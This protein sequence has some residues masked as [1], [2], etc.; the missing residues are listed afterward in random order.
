MRG[1]LTGLRVAV[2]GT[3]AAAWHAARLLGR[4]GA[5]VAAQADNH[6]AAADW[7]ASGVMA[8]TGRRDGPPV[9]PPGQTASAVRGALRAIE[10]LCA[11]AGREVDLPG[12]GVL[13]ERAALAGLRRDAP[14]SPGGAF[15]VLR[16]ADAWVGLNLPRQSDVDLL[17]AWLEEADPV[18]DEAVARRRAG[19]LAERARLLGLPF[20][21]LPSEPDEQS[22]ARG[23][24]PFVLTGEPGARSWTLPPTVV[25]DLSSLW[26]GPLCAH[27]LGLTGARVIKV[28][29][30]TRPD[31]ARRGPR[32][33]YDLLHAGHESVVLDFAAAQ[34]R[35]ALAGLLDA[36]DVVI[37]GSRPRALRQ[38]GIDADE[39]L[40]R[41]RDK[42]WIGITAYGRTGPWANVPGFGDD[43][44]L[45]AGLLAFDPGTGGPVPCGDAI[46]DPVTG[47]NAALMAVACR[48]SGG[49][50]L[51]D[52]ALREQ[53]AAT[54]VDT[55]EP[56]LPG[57]VARPRRR[58]PA[59]VAAELGRDTG[60]V[61]AE[62]GLPC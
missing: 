17:P 44:A 14:R 7:A 49:A 37:E 48:M 47:V 24:V 36:A 33:F 42:V 29:S 57:E 39:V 50:W 25:V 62:L 56:G 32:E 43:A 1:P 23:Q 13:S 59:G 19:E 61:L 22:L 31:G 30:V 11:V 40:S 58:E 8:L 41:A 55:G 46:A 38:L 51:A 2:P 15:R 45:A 26:A 20:A 9:L 52:L 18:L 54:L 21:V 35:A 5:D 12:M 16:A 27:L 53:I 4:L 34:G 6:G 28:E 10:L 3:G 60:K